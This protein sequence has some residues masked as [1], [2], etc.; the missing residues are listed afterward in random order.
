[1]KKGVTLIELLLVISIV[2]VIAGATLP[3]LSRFIVVNNLDS[4]QS[5]LN[6][7]IRRAQ[8]LSM[9]G[10]SDTNWGVCKT[11]NIIRVYSGTCNSPG[12]SEDL[13][14]S[15]SIT[16]TN[17]DVTFDSRGEPSSQVTITLSSQ[18]E[19]IDISVNAAGGINL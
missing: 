15:Q 2:A 11:G 18:I 16:I 6:F 8:A 3:F 19:S 17:F 7:A 14:F 9:D 10:K 5:K 1:M 4:A 12:V 13:S